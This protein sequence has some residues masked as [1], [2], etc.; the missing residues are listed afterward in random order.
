[1]ATACRTR[2]TRA[3]SRKL[4]SAPLVCPRVRFAV[5]RG[6]DVAEALTLAL[7]AGWDVS[8]RHLARVPMV[9]PEG[10]F[11][12]RS[13]DGEALGVASCVV[14]DDL[15]WVGSMVVHPDARKQGVGAALLDAALAHGTARGAARFGLD[16]TPM[17]RPLYERAGFVAQGE[18][19]RWRRDGPST[20]AL[21]PSGEYAI[22]PVSSCEIMELADYDKPRFGVSRA[23]LLALLMAERPHQSFVAVHRKTGAFSGLVLSLGDRIGPL[24]AETPGAAAW[25]LHACER[26]GTPPAAI[27]PSWNPAAEAL[28]AQ[29]GYLKERGC[30]RMARGTLPAGRP[31]AS[32]SLAGWAYG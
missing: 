14:W 13:S 11:T 12:A 16:A 27:V 5:E 8:E 17:G 29:A 26:A 21:P 19:A 3:R 18:L 10:V 28:F 20:L 30:V 24:V 6:W 22:Y 31:E 4:H 7:A 15:A 32:Y 2:S 25:L 23:R 1:M 9:E